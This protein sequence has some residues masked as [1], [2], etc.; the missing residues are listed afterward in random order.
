MEML[1]GVL[2]AAA[3]LVIQVLIGGTRLLFSFPAYL[4]LALGALLTLFGLRQVKPRPAASCLWASVIFFSYILARA[5][6]SPVP[7]LARPDI[8]SVLAGLVIYFTVACALTSARVRLTVLVLLLL[9]ALAHVLVGVIQ[10][11]YGKNF[12][13]ISFLQRF[14][15]GYRA[16]GFYVCPDHLAGFLEVA[17]IMGLSVV[18]WS[19]YPIWGKLLVAYAVGICYVGMILAGSRGGFLSATAS[20]LVFVFLSALIL[21]RYGR[22][23]FWQATWAGLVIM[24]V[25]A[26]GI[27][28]LFHSNEHLAE[29]TN[30]LANKDVRLFMWKAAL[31]Q[32]KL[33]PLTGTGSGTYLYYGRLFR[34]NAVQEDPVDVHNDYLHLLAEYGVVGAVLFL[35][36]LGTHLRSGWINYQRL[37][38]KRVAASLQLPSN[39]LGLQIGALGAVVAYIVHSV[40][41]FNLHIPANVLLLAFVFALLANAGQPRNETENAAFSP[42]RLLGPALA[43]VIAVQSI[44]LL[45]GEYF[46]ERARV[47]WTDDRPAEAIAFAERGLSFEKQNPDLYDYLGHS[48]TDLADTVTD[49]KKQETLYLAALKDFERG[50]A[51]A[52]LDETFPLELG[53]TYDELQRFPEAE[54]MF[55]EA[56][57]LDPKSTSLQEYYKGHLTRWSGRKLEETPP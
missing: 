38:P 45:P 49:K 15:Y 48:R 39:S 30:L 40:V 57:A 16:S 33:S 29:R 46:T 21:R 17:G 20:L 1:V 43:L 37:G 56:R 18:C 2:V 51:L 42:W 28:F 32:W 3:L 11:R 22:R 5:L 10:F 13:P 47:C 8:Y 55:C 23:L 4:V 24:L 27:A 34:D 31:Q 35:V 50:W 36:F 54:W 53:F 9:L 14:D 26:T 7:Y 52:P 12:M 44:R 41:D 6:F 25:I 19:R